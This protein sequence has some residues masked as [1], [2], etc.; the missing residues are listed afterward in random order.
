[1]P[2]AAPADS[3]SIAVKRQ[4]RMSGM[5]GALGAGG[6]ESMGMMEGEGN[7]EVRLTIVDF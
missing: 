1:M 4:W 5:A 2:R 3:K 6:R 7:G